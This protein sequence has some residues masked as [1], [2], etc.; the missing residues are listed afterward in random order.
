M[1]SSTFFLVSTMR[2]T[3]ISTRSTT[4]GKIVTKNKTR[5]QQTNKVHLLLLNFRGG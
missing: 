1:H 4:D 3:N 5:K 2:M